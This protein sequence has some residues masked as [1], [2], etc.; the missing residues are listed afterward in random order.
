M[1]AAVVI[2]RIAQS[3]AKLK[4]KLR[5]GRRKGGSLDA[6]RSARTLGSYRR[7]L[8]VDRKNPCGGGRGRRFLVLDKLPKGNYPL[9]RLFGSGINN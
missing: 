2:S 1:G 9:N 7:G 8:S 6:M 5:S 4:T 3:R